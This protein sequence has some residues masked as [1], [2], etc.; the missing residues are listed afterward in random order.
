MSFAFAGRL[1]KALRSPA[2]A[3]ALVFTTGTVAAQ[4]AAAPRRSPLMTRTQGRAGARGATGAAAA[5][6][7]DAAK[8]DEA[9]ERFQSST[10][11]SAKPRS[12][13]L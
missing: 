1:L 6:A 2:I 7:A 4:Q 5:Q 9:M 11:R 12:S 8:G 3:V 10:S 13:T